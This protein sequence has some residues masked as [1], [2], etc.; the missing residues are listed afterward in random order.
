MI[1]V[2]R[3]VMVGTRASDYSDQAAL[4]LMFF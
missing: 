1:Y 4:Q 2:R 3:G